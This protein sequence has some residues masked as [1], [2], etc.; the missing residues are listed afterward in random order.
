MT[1][2][3]MLANYRRRGWSLVPI[4]AG[5][6][7]PRIKDWQKRVF[8]PSDFGEGCNVGLILGPRSGELVDVD[9][10]CQEA[11]PL[12]SIYLPP[13]E[14]MFGRISKPRAHRL[15]VAIGAVF[16]AFAD[17][18]TGDT[19]LELRAAG[20]DGG[21]HQTIIPP[22]VANGE[23]RGWSD[24][25]IAP[26]V[27]GAK[28]LRCAA[29]WLAIGCLV[30]RHVSQHAA[31][32]PGPD[33]PQLL[34]EFDHGLGRA[35]YHWLDQPAPD[36][37]RHGLQPRPR[38]QWSAEDIDLVEMMRAVPNNADWI[39]W[40]NIG[41]AI[42]AATGGSDDGGA[43]FDNWSAKS[44]KYNPYTTVER[45][46][47]FRRSPPCRTGLGKLVKLALEAGWRPA[48]EKV[49]SAK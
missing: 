25:T 23:A 34:W 29:A 19:L 44:P 21:A 13:T 31:E 27:I 11:L 49:R 38:A 42:Y 39:E 3:E 28:A 6:K 18:E 37:P 9:L 8:E 40:T 48:T 35:A 33:L 5:A 15:Y 4:P 16:E 45:W 20:R 17:P 36:E 2:D 12:A 43:V 24:D 22:S 30:M 26:G 1:R 46:R 10:D 32:R 14:A 41:L 7:G 47:H